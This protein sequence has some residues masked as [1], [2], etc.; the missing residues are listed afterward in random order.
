MQATLTSRIDL[1]KLRTAKNMLALMNKS[2]TKQIIDLLE[3]R[4]SVCVTD[5]YVRLRCDQAVVSQR[6][7]LML[8]H[9]LVFAERQGK[10]I[11][12]SLNKD[13]FEQ[14][15]NALNNFFGK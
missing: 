13:R 11:Y 9:N 4:A 6:L 10:W 1:E 5:I 12:Y 8:K 3:E 15:N 14:I 7:A 2:K